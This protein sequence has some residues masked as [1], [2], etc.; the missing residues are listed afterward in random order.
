MF[1][2]HEKDVDYRFGDSGPKYFM[3]G[4]RIG[5]GQARLKVGEDF[6]NHFHNDMEEIFFMLKGKVE[7]VIDGK[8]YIGEKGDLYSIAPRETH[9]LKNVGDEEAI[10][11]FCLAPFEDGDKE[12]VP[13]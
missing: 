1:H 4:P 8:S 3:R 13:L 9:Y 5:I 10:V 12:N 6:V 2:I 11:L 7:F